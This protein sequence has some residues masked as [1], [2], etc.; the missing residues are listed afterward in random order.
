MWFLLI[1][2]GY[3][4]CESHF[5]LPQ[6][7]YDILVYCDIIVTFLA[8]MVP[9]AIW[10]Y[11]RAAEGKPDTWRMAFY[12]VPACVLGT[13][14]ATIYSLIGI[15]EASAF[16]A[17]RFATGDHPLGFD[18]PLF[19]MYRLWPSKIFMLVFMIEFLL[20]IGA[21]L[22]KAARHKFSFKKVYRFFFK[23]GI[24]N[25]LDLIY[26]SLMLVMIV[27]AV[28]L[29]FGHFYLLD[30]RHLSAILSLL[31][32]ILIYVMASLA[33][34]P[35]KSDISLRAVIN[36][37]IWREI[38]SQIPDDAIEEEAEQQEAVPET[39]PVEQTGQSDEKTVQQHSGQGVVYQ[40]ESPA[41][42]KESLLDMFNKCMDEEQPY[43]DPNLNIED[44]AAR[45][46]TNKTYISILVNQNL[47]MTFRSYI[48][49][50]RIEQA[51]ALILANPDE[52]LD[53][54]ATD[55]GFLSS[56]QLNKKFKEIEG[57]SPRQWQI[58]HYQ[59]NAKQ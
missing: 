24:C 25:P 45:L 21:I 53:F 29:S 15:E 46:N 36:P 52:L 7:R 14:S 6:T 26:F 31:T 51:K 57:I 56:S 11:I 44:L 2:S 58:A 34:V 42:V 39:V 18:S 48:N 38:K 32:A 37:E 4:F 9:P 50:K 5:I 27:S 55:S 54:I 3:F 47:N 33:T 10:M 20:T 16:Q 43:L 1:L 30:H 22:V 19:Q 12:F 17:A 28:R 23:G 59:A 40:Q 35:F 8:L 49:I 13:M 41:L